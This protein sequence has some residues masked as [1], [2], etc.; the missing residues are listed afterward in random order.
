MTELLPDEVTSTTVGLAA[1]KVLH[2]REFQRQRWSTDHDK[3]HSTS[4]WVSIL[5]VYLGKAAISSE[6]YCA[7]NDSKSKELFKKRLIQLSAICIA[8]IESMDS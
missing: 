2:E 6:P 4:D 8:A 1:K 7:T 5:A 3:Q